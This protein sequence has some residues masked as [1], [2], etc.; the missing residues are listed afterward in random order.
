M[1]TIKKILFFLLLPIV[2]MLSFPPDFYLQGLVVM[3]VVVVLII[4]LGLIIWR[5]SQRALTF[6]IF[7]NGMNV[8]TRLMMLM[9]TVISK[10]GQVNLP[11]AFTGL[12]G[13]I[14]SFYLMLRLDQPDVRKYVDIQALSFKKPTKVK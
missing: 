7:L 5:G 6:A 11:F 2:G 12:L 9:S 1:S 8:I 14:V 4:I 3:T 10:Q 13:L